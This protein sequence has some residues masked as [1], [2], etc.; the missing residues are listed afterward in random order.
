MFDGFL[1]R[2]RAFLLLAALS[3]LI[4]SCG[5]NPAAEESCFEG[6]ESCVCRADAECIEGLQCRSGYCVDVPEEQE[7]LDPLEPNELRVYQP[8]AVDDRYVF[9]TTRN[10]VTF[11]RNRSGNVTQAAWRSKDGELDLR[12]QFDPQSGNVTRFDDLDTGQFTV[13]ERVSETRVDVLRYENTGLYIEGLAFFEE[14]G[15]YKM[16]RILGR[17]AFEGQ[18]T[19]QM[20]AEDGS[21]GSFAVTA[22]PGETLADV[23]HFDTGET[24]LLDAYAGAQFPIGLALR[25]IN[26]KSGLQFTGG[27][28]LVGAAAG[29]AFGLSAGAAAVAGVCSILASFATDMVADAVE[30]K[31]RFDDPVAQ[32]FV[33]YAVEMLRG[34]GAPEGVRNRIGRLKDSLVATTA[35]IAE[36]ADEFVTSLDDIELVSIDDLKRDVGGWIDEASLPISIDGPDILDVD[37]DGFGIWDDGTSYEIE[38]IVDEFGNLILEATSEEGGTFEIEGELDESGEEIEGRIEGER[39]GRLEARSEEISACDVVA[40]SGGQGATS[41][42]HYVGE[43]SGTVAFSYQAFSIP[44][45]FTAHTGGRKVYDSGGLVSGSGTAAIPVGAGDRVVF[46]SVFAPRSGTAWNY[47]LGCLP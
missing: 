3:I 12:V 39:R 30:E 4:M 23:R 37:V 7:P 31:F 8:S 19:G 43:G 40:R 18:I 10:E 42:A 27:V 34:P 14:G 44:D 9:E 28:L 35:G 45:A 11:F 13:I 6:H 29:G 17:A 32:N 46:I 47:N 16:A 36:A 5:G 33:D 15:H 22:D 20:T 1:Y 24:A 26:F 41:K 21:S 2:A 38:G 25:S